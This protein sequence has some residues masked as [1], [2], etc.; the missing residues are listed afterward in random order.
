[1]SWIANGDL[2]LRVH[3]TYALSEAREAQEDLASR[4]T[5]GKLLLAV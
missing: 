1:M 4:K 2:L 5:T 3:K